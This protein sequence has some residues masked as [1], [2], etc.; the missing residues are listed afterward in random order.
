MTCEDNHVNCLE[1]E[2]KINEHQGKWF[3]YQDKD[4]VSCAAA[5]G[6]NKG[7]AEDDMGVKTV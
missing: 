2:R 6:N 1:M 3:V 7:Q 4:C 5:M